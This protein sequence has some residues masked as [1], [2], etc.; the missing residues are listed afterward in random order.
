MLDL[1]EGYRR[2]KA[3]FGLMDFSDQIALAAELARLQPE[4][5][6]VERGST[7]WCCW[8]STRTPRSRR[9]RCS[10]PCS[11]A[12]SRRR[13]GARGHGGR[14]SQPGDLR[15]AGRL[16]VQ[17]PQLR[18]HLPVR[19]GGR[20]AVV[21]RS[22][23]TGVRTPHPRRRQRPGAAAVRRARPGRSRC[24]RR[25]ARSRE[26]A[27][28]SCTRRT[29]DELAWLA[30]QVTASHARWPSRCWSE[31][32]VLTRDNSHAADV[33]DALTSREIPVE[34][35]GL[36]GLM[37]LPEVSEVVSTLSLLQDLTANADLLNLLNGPR[38]A[39]GPRDLA[40]LGRRAR[41]AD[42]D[43]A[44]RGGHH[45]RRRAA[46]RRRG[47]RPDR[48]R[49]R[50]TTRSA[51]PGDRPT[52]RRRASG[53]RCCRGA[54][55]LRAY[56]GEPLLDLV[57]RIIDTTGIDIELASS[58]V[59]GRGGAPRQPRPV[60]QGGRRVPG[61]RR[62]GDAARPCWPG[63]RPR[64]R[65][66]AASTRPRRRGRLGEA[67]D[68]PPCQGARV[69]SVFLVGVCAEKFP[70]DRARSQ[71]TT[72]GKVLPAPLRGD[73]ADVPQLRGYDKPAIVELT[74][75]APRRTR[76]RG[77]PARLRRVHPGQARAAG[78]RRTSGARRARSRCCR[79]RTS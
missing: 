52:P 66:A 48:G 1:V 22:R 15:L 6:R 10:A 21:L 57:R 31:I 77:A 38:W 9:P 47:R 3:Q 2:L 23:S 73:A 72:V 34:I 7:A 27:A 67:A 16:G 26:R 44:A 32:G 45:G 24:S 62:P 54:A 41:D 64:T 5:G 35:V 51:D 28:P 33:F 65:W 18:R 69:V 50:S 19:H 49:S 13:A 12:R 76:G 20:R 42:R 29:H 37:R 53:S 75:A 36:K 71:W 58:V 40:L 43:E 14:R 56:V 30:E 74:E 8:T 11:P 55:R 59:A 25:T 63:S 70:V 79:R 4:V 78:S 39:I 60:R 61:H 17:H 68:R 46:A